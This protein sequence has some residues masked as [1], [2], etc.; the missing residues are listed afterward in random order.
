MQD[1]LKV[2][3]MSCPQL[4][5]LA[6]AGVARLQRSF[7]ARECRWLQ[8][9]STKV[10]TD[11]QVIYPLFGVFGSVFRPQP[12]SA[13]RTR[14]AFC[15]ALARLVGSTSANGARDGSTRLRPWALAR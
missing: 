6:Q 10:P 3:K 5:R 15:Q 11:F 12:H 2:K 13:R 4:I 7:S 14:H 1:T 9:N 8:A